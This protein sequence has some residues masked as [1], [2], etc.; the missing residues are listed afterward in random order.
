MT[1]AVV[2]LLA[3]GRAAAPY[4][5]P[6]DAVMGE[7]WAEVE[8]DRAGRARL[9][10]SGLAAAHRQDIA[11]YGG[12]GQPGRK[13]QA[14]I[15]MIRKGGASDLR[16]LRAQMA[17][18]SRGG[19]Q[20]LQRSERYMGV[21]VDAE[22]AAAIETAWRM[23]Q[24]GSGAADRTSHFIVSFPESTPHG[25][26]E[27]AG[28][29]WAEELF[30]SGDYGGDAYDYYTAFH[31]DRAHPHMHVVVHRRGLDNGEWLKV[32]R[33]SDVN[34]DT[35]RAVLVE[36]AG[37]EGIALEA[38]PRLARGVHDRPV[39]DAEYRRAWEEK[40]APVAP[41]HS[42]ETAIRAAAALIHYARRF[43]SDARAIE[44]EA[45]EQA[46]LLRAASEA[47]AHGRA[48]TDSIYTPV[49]P[50][51]E[52]DMSSARVEERREEVRQNF[53]KMDR[54]VEQMED[55][56][57]RMRVLR[58]IDELKT[59]SAPM[60]SDP[61][62]LRDFAVK[63]D[64]GRYQGID[65]SDPRRAGIKAEADEKVV[66]VAARYGVDGE[67]TVE[68]YSGGVPSKGLAAEFAAAE[69]RE[70]GRTRVE[71]GEGPE[72]A[73]ERRSALARMHDEVGAIYQEAR[74]HA[75]R[76]EGREVGR[77]FSTSER[78]DDGRG[79]ELPD[80]GRNRA[81]YAPSS[82]ANDAARQQ[83]RNAETWRQVQAER[84][85]ERA[86]AERREGVRRRQEREDEERAR[87][88]RDNGR[89]L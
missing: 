66:A 31:T 49:A 65:A 12:G 86:E 18:L 25:A 40:R 33:R 63:D 55:G 13:P 3:R 81:D 68:R 72:S 77:R 19:E 38:T 44:R 16:G 59:R 88:E 26:A 11:R 28:R 61:G 75:A 35:M 1:V 41:E 45:P 5:S 47:I 70:R 17:Y 2:D 67:A 52:N 50:E 6:L 56:A 30:G 8:F 85:A 20:I 87:R 78:T 43:A 42:P 37:R 23:P 48:L 53:E 29:A 39:P 15:K 60:M 62:Q 89:G 58:Q 82:V 4:V 36:V 69:E 14:V 9:V 64:S 79:A 24:D 57:S 76:G 54:G 73:D 27:R 10:R 74:E 21:E 71:R 80:A 46:A 32:S 51:Q 84:S 7:D 22:Q 83:A 34:Y